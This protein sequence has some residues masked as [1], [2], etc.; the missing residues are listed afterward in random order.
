MSYGNFQ[1]KPMRFQVGGAC[2]TIQ[3]VF[4][5]QYPTDLKIDYYE[6]FVIRIL[7]RVLM[8]EKRFFNRGC[9]LKY[10]ARFICCFLCIKRDNT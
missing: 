7:I 2:Q 3:H 1:C 9:Q 5:D 6:R 10:R 8:Q 4:S